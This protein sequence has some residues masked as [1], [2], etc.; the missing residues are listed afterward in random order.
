MYV[1][2]RNFLIVVS[3][4]I[5]IVSDL[6]SSHL[7]TFT[8]DA[9]TY[10]ALSNASKFQVGSIDVGECKDSTAKSLGSY[11]ICVIDTPLKGSAVLMPAS[12]SGNAAT[13]QGS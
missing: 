12:E 7:T 2:A 9:A 11:K 13:T 3:H 6:S 8:V 5:Q 1:Y 10:K 4:H